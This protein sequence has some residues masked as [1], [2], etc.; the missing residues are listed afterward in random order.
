[1]AKKNKKQQLTAEQKETIALAQKVM[2]VADRKG[3]VVGLS[4]T[5]YLVGVMMG[6]YPKITPLEAEAEPDTD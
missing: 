3:K 5:E 4:G 6:K 2:K 1:M